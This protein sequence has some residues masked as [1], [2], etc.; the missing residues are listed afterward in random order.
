MRE[1]NK[2]KEQVEAYMRRP[3]KQPH[4]MSR[5]GATVADIE[6]EF[7]DWKTW[8]NRGEGFFHACIPWDTNMYVTAE[9][10]PALRDG[11]IG[12]IR[13]REYWKQGV[14]AL[15]PRWVGEQHDFRVREARRLLARNCQ[16]VA[17]LRNYLRLLIQLADDAADTELNDERTYTLLRGGMHI[18]AEDLPLL[19]ETCSAKLAEVE[20]SPVTAKSSAQGVLKGANQNTT[21]GLLPSLG[22]EVVL[23]PYGRPEFYQRSTVE[24][25]PWTHQQILEDDPEESQ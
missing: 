17:V 23:S 7:P 16:D 8:L 24:V 9:S 14:V 15:A 5:E 3:L 18:R 1:R 4:G 11:I 6:K 13:G 22:D 25:I 20:V 10:V 19:C 12:C 21:V 2:Q